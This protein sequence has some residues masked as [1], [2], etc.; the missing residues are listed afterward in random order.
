MRHILNSLNLLMIK[1]TGK[2]SYMKNSLDVNMHAFLLK[3]ALVTAKF[4]GIIPELDL[5]YAEFVDLNVN[6]VLISRITVIGVLLL[7][8]WI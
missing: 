7:M 4:L 2:M 3:D 6:F 5:Y 8:R 1:N